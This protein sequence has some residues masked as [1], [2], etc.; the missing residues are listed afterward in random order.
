MSD[1]AELIQQHT[2][3]VE[4]KLEEYKTL[5][6]V[7]K[8]RLDEMEQRV[9][10]RTPGAGGGTEAS[11]GERVAESAEVKSLA[12][13]T[14]SQPGRVRVELKEITSGAT[15][16]GALYAPMRD[17]NINTIAGRTPRLRNLLTV[18]NTSTGAVEYLDQT[19][20]T[21]N[22]APQVEGALK[23]ES[24]YAW[25]LR[26]LPMRTIA[27]WTKA[28]VQ[29]L[30]DA[31]Q[32]AST[33][34]GELRYGLAIAEDV[35]LLNGSGVSPNLNGLITNATAYAAAFAQTGENMIDKVGLGMLQVALAEHLPNG[36]VLHPSDWMR[37]RMLKDADGKYLLGDPGAEIEPR[38]FGLPA[39]LTTAIA[40]D[41]F[42]IGDF[43]KAA[44]LYD[45]QAATLALSTEDGDNFVTN[46]VTLRLEER[47]GLAI[48]QPTALSYGDFG[49]IV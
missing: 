32:L 31:P 5:S 43:R 45:R 19:I 13:V 41:K 22:A 12:S 16:G 46:R 26:T 24:N 15:S 38:L 2:D 36:I 28:S 6:G 37:M 9:A 4:L 25:E 29:I 48:K 14:A 33:I 47:L 3:G 42:L 11:W 17:P 20:K 21:N 8:A 10:A 18:V 7:I 40:A 49:N 35:Q 30:D 23:A 44:T 34:D 27:H 39:V 1:I